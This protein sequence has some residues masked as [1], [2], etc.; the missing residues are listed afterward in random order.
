MEFNNFFF[1]SPLLPKPLTSLVFLLVSFLLSFLL[2]VTLLNKLLGQAWNIYLNIRAFT[3][4][5]CISIHL[6]WGFNTAFRFFS[7][8]IRNNRWPSSPLNTEQSMAIIILYVLTSKRTLNTDDSASDKVNAL[9]CL[10]CDQ[11]ASRKS[12]ACL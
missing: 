5:K 3:S 2:K 7:R 9:E 10:K 6:I 12:M 1:S 8:N 4:Q 11:W